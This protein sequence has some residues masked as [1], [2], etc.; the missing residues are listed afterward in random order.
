MERK[1]TKPDNH[2]GM[3]FAGNAANE[4]MCSATAE[5][6]QKGIVASVG[7]SKR[8]NGDGRRADSSK[9]KLQQQPYWLG[10]QTT[11]QPPETLSDVLPG[12]ERDWYWQGGPATAPAGNAMRLKRK[13]K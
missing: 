5:A 10:R 8:E 11:R 1:E 2:S 4:D 9:G 3:L 13:G 6:Q 12:Q 7:S